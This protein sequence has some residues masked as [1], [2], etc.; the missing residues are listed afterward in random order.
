[1]GKA[2]PIDYITNYDEHL[3][4]KPPEKTKEKL[5]DEKRS[6][7]EKPN[8]KNESEVRSYR[9]HGDGVKE[10][11]FFLVYEKAMTPGQAAKQL[12]VNR[13]L[14]NGKKVGRPSILN[15]VHKKHLISFYDDNPSAV[16]DQAMASL[17][18]KFAG[19]KIGK[20]AVYN[21]MTSEC[22]LTFKKA[23][24]Y[25]I[26]RNSP[27]NIER[28]YEWVLNWVKETDM[29]YMS[30]CV[31]ID[32]AAFHINLKRSMA[33]SKKGTRAEVIVPETRARTT[34]ILGAI[35]PFGIVNIQ[36]RRP[37][38]PS[39]KR[40]LGS[41]DFVANGAGG[42]VTGHYINFVKSTL[43]VLDNHEEFKGHYI[44][45]DNAPTHTSKDIER[46]IT[47]RGYGCI[48]LPPYSPELNPIKNF[49]K[50]RRFPVE[51]KKHATVS[52][53][54]T[55]KDFAIIPPQNFIIA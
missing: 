33:W 8:K 32:E 7:H 13:Q 48:C 39:K 15:E 46:Y 24:M 28:R 41:N 21:F 25:S 29:D 38:I 14:N 16:V 22:N 54:A 11:L 35:S 1:M 10:Q 2:Y 37:A 36:L 40:R 34:T 50:K 45:M 9:K 3:D 20:T 51:S 17:T 27:D 47:S 26:Q 55:F 43:D 12:G 31:F 5:H 49:W 6:L 19:L 4:C 44:V 53:L 30:N 23:H 42:T 52:S 18:S